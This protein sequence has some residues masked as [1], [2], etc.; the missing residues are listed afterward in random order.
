MPQPTASDVHVNRPLTNLS[1]AYI[2]QR[3]NFVADQVFAPVRVPKQSD[4]YY[5]YTK[6][7]WFRNEAEVR[8]DA[9]ESAGS[10]YNLSSTNSYFSDV[11]AIHKDVGNQS[12][13]NSDGGIDLDR[14]ATEFVTQRMLVRKE[15]DWVTAYF[16]TG[17]WGTTTTP[18]N[19]WSSV[20]TSDPIDDIEGGID[21][22]LVAKSIRNTAGEGQTASYSFNH[23]RHA[24]L[25]YVNS[26]PS[27]LAP[28]AGY[29]FLWTG[30]S[31]LGTD[32]TISR[33]YM[34]KLKADRIE[35][36]AAY[37]YRITGSDLGYFFNAAVST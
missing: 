28:S 23:G 15:V 4:R 9:T 34:D 3:S 12:R 31:G 16:S 36:E 33:F 18:S 6:A 5:V 29:N 14:D 24:L 1:I 26:T 22:V 19:L 32:I 35:A 10:G 37:D 8:A 7:D 30:V 17:V 25:C 20:T 21:R 27:M 2:Q 13:A 11:V